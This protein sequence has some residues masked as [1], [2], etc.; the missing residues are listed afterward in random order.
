M[1]AFKITREQVE[2]ERAARLRATAE[3]YT[4]QHIADRRNFDLAHGTRLY[5]KQLA[6]EAVRAL[7]NYNFTLSGHM[8]VVVGE[9]ARKK[10]VSEGLVLTSSRRDFVKWAREERLNRDLHVKRELG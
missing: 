8:W 2:A 5:S 9:M 10:A 7:N 3:H 6:R 1:T 4:R